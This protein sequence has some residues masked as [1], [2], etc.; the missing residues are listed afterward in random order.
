[1]TK[2]EPNEPEKPIVAFKTAQ[3]IIAELR[4]LNE[5]PGGYHLLHSWRDRYR[6]LEQKLA[7]LQKSQ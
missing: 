7:S 6:K 2:E 1:M 4:R 3:E 5:M